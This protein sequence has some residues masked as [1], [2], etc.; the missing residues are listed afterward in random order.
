MISC[1][2]TSYDPGHHH[3]VTKNNYFILMMT[4]SVRIKE[5]RHQTE[6]WF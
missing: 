3:I 4:A 1:P 5:L 6:L 2:I